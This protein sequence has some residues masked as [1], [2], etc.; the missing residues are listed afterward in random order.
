MKYFSFSALAVAVMMTAACERPLIESEEPE[1]DDSGL[2]VPDQSR[3]KKFTFTLKG[4]FSNEWKPVSHRAA[5]Y[6]SADGKDL[7]DV[8][9]LDYVGGQLVQQ[10]HQ[11]DNT[12]EDFGQ[13]SMNLKYGVHHV[14]FIASRGGGAQ[15]DTDAK[16]ITFD[17]VLDT[18]YQDYEVSV[19]STSNGNRAV[20]LDRVVTRLR[21]TF[22][23]AVADGTATI[24]VTPNTWYYGFD[25]TDGTPTA[26]KT[27]QPMSITIPASEIGKT[28]LQTSIY[29]FSD[30]DEWTTDVSIR[31]QKADQTVIG[32]AVIKDAPFKANRI[33]EYSGQL[34]G[35]EG[36]M[37]I[38]LND[39][40]EDSFQGTW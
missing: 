20:T 31:S 29:G 12:A 37:S 28:G 17:K 35:S 1:V 13:P 5:G 11:S 22:I 24:S 16:T 18:F 4:D 8:W 21:L 26:A 32:Q 6:L 25:Y 36:K 27:F 19:V 33:T 15:L 10:L 23:D 40:W 2:V 39:T 38:S 30:S 3:V 14:Y 7:T 9:V 34:F